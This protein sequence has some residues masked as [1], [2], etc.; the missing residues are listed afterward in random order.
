MKILW[1]LIFVTAGLIFGQTPT[2]TSTTTITA[3][4][5]SLVCVGTPSV[6]ASGVSTMNMVCK[7]GTTTLHTSDS[8]VPSSPGTGIAI[9]VSSGSNSVTWLL[10]K[11]NPSPDGWQ[12]SVTDGTVTKSKTGVF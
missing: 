5:G 4:V 6:D 11:G 2:V 8:A 3:S 10:T 7:V 9:S 1:L 12:V